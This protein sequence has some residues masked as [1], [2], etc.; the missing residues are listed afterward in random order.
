M[1][2]ED[3]N[4]G[5]VK[6]GSMGGGSGLPI[7]QSWQPG[8]LLQTNKAYQIDTPYL[9]PMGNIIEQSTVDY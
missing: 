3:R 4:Q 2:Y 6:R 1:D 7:F 9:I 8:N 5:R